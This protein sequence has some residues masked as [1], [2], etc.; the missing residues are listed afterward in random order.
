LVSLPGT[1]GMTLRR[2]A[3]LAT[4]LDDPSLKFRPW[5]EA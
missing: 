3:S 1:A 4:V 5:V 2:P